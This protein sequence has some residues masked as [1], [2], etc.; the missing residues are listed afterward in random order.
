MILG[1]YNNRGTTSI[2][3]D[4]HELVSKKGLKEYL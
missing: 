3:A 2:L 1:L 4:G